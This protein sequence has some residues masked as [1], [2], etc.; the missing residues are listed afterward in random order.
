MRARWVIVV[1][2][3]CLVVTVAA[4]AYA[5]GKTSAPEVIRAQRF[6]LV[7]DEGRVRAA[8][9]V[10]GGDPD[11]ALHDREG[12]S[13]AVLSMVGGSPRLRLFHENGEA[14]IGLSEFRGGALISAL[15]AGP[16]GPSALLAVAPGEAGLGLYDDKGRQRA[17]VASLAICAIAAAPAPA[18]EPFAERFDR[19][20]RATPEDY[21]AERASLLAVGKPL[22]PFLAERQKLAQSW[23]E[24]AIAA[25]LTLAVESP[26][27]YRRYQE[28]F[29][30]QTLGG[31]RGGWSAS[32]GLWERQSWRR[33]ISAERPFFLQPKSGSPGDVLLKE[34]AKAVP[35]LIE[36]LFTEPRQRIPD[37]TVKGYHLSRPELTAQRLLTQMGGKEAARVLAVVAIAKDRSSEDVYQTSLLPDSE[38]VDL[39]HGI[40]GLRQQ[41]R[42]AWALGEF[43]DPRSLEP[44]IH[45]VMT[46]GYRLD[47]SAASQQAIGKYGERAILPLLAELAGEPYDQGNWLIGK[48]GEQRNWIPRCLRSL[49]PAVLEAVLE[50]ERT[51]LRDGYPLTR[52]QAIACIERLEGEEAAF[53]ALK[54]IWPGSLEDGRALWLMVFAMP[55]SSKCEELVIQQG[56]R[57]IPI[58]RAAL[59]SRAR[60]VQAGAAH[61]LAG[62]GLAGLP[63]LVDAA[64][65]PQSQV[66]RS[67]ALALRMLIGAMANG[68]PEVSRSAYDSLRKLTRQ[69]LP[70]VA[71][72]WYKWWGQ[73]FGP[74]PI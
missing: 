9:D 39:L 19:M 15:G 72:D 13:R 73:E 46:A 49:G 52:R 4:I 48:P 58:L 17:R 61:S 28:A 67:R 38:L 10:L 53:S 29:T 23:Y 35:F 24:R 36:K 30:A 26:R 55:N 74:G 62:M 18:E 11:V 45:S 40:L 12:R 16:P 50:T 66:P 64:S 63:V 65:W 20:L 41:P 6:E 32:A 43:Q 34:G 1:V 7:D 42:A 21:Q 27:T 71:A 59:N 31:G 69:D 33:Q 47:A 68:S 60:D 57:A 37:R 70:P 5:A 51:S 3:V 14:A 54:N 8:L 25:A 22:I 44:L 56:R 2:A